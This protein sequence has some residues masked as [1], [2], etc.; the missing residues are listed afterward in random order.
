MKPSSPPIT[1]E[2]TFVDSDGYVTVLRHRA[3]F[4]STPGGHRIMS[5][6]VESRALYSKHLERVAILADW[7]R[8][9]PDHT[10]DNKTPC[11]ENDFIPGFDGISFGLML[12][13]ARPSAV[14]EIG[15]GSSTKFIRSAIEYLGLDT[16][17]ISI[18]PSPRAEIEALCD[19]SIRKGLEESVKEVLEILP[20]RPLIFFDG[21][22]RALPNSDVVSFFLE[23]LPAIPSGCIYGIHDIVLPCDYPPIFAERLY[24]E[25]YVL[26]AYLLGGADGD[27]IELP[28]CYLTKTGEFKSVLPDGIELL[29][30]NGASFWLRKA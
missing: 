21:S 24:S 1:T 15:S 3:E 26:A 29:Y 2:P 14:L 19:T 23:I 25:Q 17:I 6:V 16:R 20:S 30:P 22:H 8:S 18:D 27:A 28:T 5:L 11:W 12:L 4:P 7:I 13:D 9:I 10:R